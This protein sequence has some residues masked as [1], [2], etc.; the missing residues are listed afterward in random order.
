MSK[1]AVLLAWSSPV[2]TEMD[3]EFNRW[4][5]DVH[6]PQVIEAVGKPTTVTRRTLVDPRSGE[7]SSVPKYLAV[8]EF[9]DIDVV[10]ANTALMGTFRAQK[11][12]VSLTIDAKAGAMQWYSPLGSIGR[13]SPR[14]RH[15][16]TGKAAHMARPTA[17]PRSD[18]TGVQLLLRATIGGT[19]I[20][21]RIKH[22]RSIDGTAGWFGSI[23][24][25]QPKLQAL[26]SAVVEIGA[27]SAIVAGAGTPVPPQWSA[28]WRL[29]RARSIC[30]MDSSSP[31]RAGSTSLTSQ[32]PP[33]HSRRWDPAGSAST[34]RLVSTARSPEVAAALAAGLGLIRAGAQLAAARPARREVITG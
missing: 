6:V 13:Q 1:K 28:P 9:E 16:R 4:Y 10:A 17:M 30:R 3:V 26:A 19:M 24:F 25:K 20:A 22:G 8:Y 29:R 34:G 32:L 21:H 12:D 23:G 31:P 2:S 5:E 14:D 15:Q 33:W 27:G 18:T 7:N 11:L